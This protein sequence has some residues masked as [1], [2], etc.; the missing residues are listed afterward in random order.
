MNDIVVQ[1]Q[2]LTKIYRLYDK[3]RDRLLEA[4]YPSRKKYH[5][6]FYALDGV[7][8]EVRKGEAIGI[9]GEN[10]A[11]KS[12]LLKI[13]TGVLSKTSGNVFVKGKVAS[14]LELGAG[15]NPELTGY[16]N[17][18]L[19]GSL[20][21]LSYVEM[22]G[23]VNAI[24]DFADIGEYIHQ[25]VKLY[26]SGM[27]AR[28]AFAVA[29]NVEPDVLI[30]DEALSV[31]DARFQRK[32]YA[33][34]EKMS[35]D[36]V[37]IILVSHD[38]ESIKTFTSKCILIS[39]AK[40]H[41]EGSP[42]DC[43]IEYLKLL[44]GSKEE[45]CQSKSDIEKEY[46]GRSDDYVCFNKTLSKIQFGKGHADFDYLH[47]RGLGSSNVFQGGEKLEIKYKISWDYD[48]LLE[49]YQLKNYD[50]NLIVGI[51]LIDKKGFTYFGLN[52]AIN[53]IPIDPN[54]GS[55]REQIIKFEMPLLAPGEYFLTAA[56][57]F[58]DH[59]NH[60]QLRWYDDAIELR[61]VPHK[62]HV[63]GILDVPHAFDPMEA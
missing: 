2:N 62:K 39:D 41:F 34:I 60:I 18:F 7:S 1:V 25:P 8:F 46:K 26:S 22:Q 44:F 9:I 11:G 40:I 61:C 30:V 63:I 52:T 49:E 17:I 29:I 14:L 37:A 56:I 59:E 47:L 42:K 23:K 54:R 24:L 5:Q 45:T 6:D 50:K 28:L 16:E 55:T 36:G 48:I 13:L 32:C 12:T 33:K 4:F 15:F 20:M 57:A 35:K 38:L 43:V 10:G 27:F 19:H 31:G 3:P 58:G 51:H 53:N 21:G